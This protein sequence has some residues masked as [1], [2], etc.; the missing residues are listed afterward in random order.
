MSQ[1]PGLP[2]W[3][4]HSDGRREPFNAETIFH[5]LFRASAHLGSPDPFRAREL[6]DA[7]LHFLAESDPGETLGS[8]EIRDVTVKVTREL[9]HVSLAAALSEVHAQSDD[10][11]AHPPEIVV[12]ERTG[13]LTRGNIKDPLKL[14]GSVLTPSPSVSQGDGTDMAEALQAARAHTG[15]YVA[16]DGPEFLFSDVGS[17]EITRSWP[18][19]LADGVRRS[20]LWAV[21]NLNCRTSPPWAVCPTGGLFP[22]HSQERLAQQRADTCDAILD[23]LATKGPTRVRIDWHLGDAD[24]EPVQRARL[25][26]VCRHIQEGV[27]LALVMDRARRPVA[28]AEGLDREHQAVFGVVGVRVDALA[29]HLASTGRPG[30]DS[31]MQAM[32]ALGSLARSE[33]NA[34]LRLLRGHGGDEVTRGF[35]LDRARLVVVP[36]GLTE[37]IDTPNCSWTDKAIAAQQLRRAIL[38]GL[39][40]F[41]SLG[42]PAV[43]DSTPPG[44][45]FGESP[46]PAAGDSPLI[47]LNRAAK[48]QTDTE[49]G[50]AN[51]RL[52]AD[53][54][55]DVAN[56]ADL[57]DFAFRLPGLVRVQFNYERRVAPTP[58]ARSISG[59]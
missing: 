13:V 52:P 59:D 55:N 33:G 45:D 30:E 44:A 34:R 1:S 32:P 15:H 51:I 2:G 19:A 7:V 4:V 28:L 43:L 50:T 14:A 27:N 40:R 41:P 3:I 58:S 48:L 18:R 23:E 24:F 10:T 56:M 49:T 20:G 9:G 8:D 25:L 38:G 16:I 11:D 35:S 57:I 5:R 26:R 17:A 47:Q 6:A 31:L 29:R 36:V 22:D 37:A 46:D 42:P 53:L 54:I 12:A 21:V 39:S